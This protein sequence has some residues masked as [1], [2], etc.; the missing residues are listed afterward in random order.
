MRHL[1]FAT[2]TTAVLL[3]AGAFPDCVRAADVAPPPAYGPRSGYGRPP[4]YSP[5]HESGPPPD[6]G[7]R[8]Y[9]P[10]PGYVTRDEDG[11]PPAYGPARRAYS[12][13]PT[14]RIPYTSWPHDPS[15][16]E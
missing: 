8:V 1:S 4:G 7:R 3:A 2:A 16:R 5:L 11:P 15:F 6:Y 10:L 9:G 12:P 13:S 14:N